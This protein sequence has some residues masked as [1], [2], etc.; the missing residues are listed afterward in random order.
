MRSGR[1]RLEASIAPE[2]RFNGKGGNF[3]EMVQGNEIGHGLSSACFGAPSSDTNRV[4]MWTIKYAIVKLP[5]EPSL[6]WICQ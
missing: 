6:L 4:S 2:S 3:V 1:S 5:E